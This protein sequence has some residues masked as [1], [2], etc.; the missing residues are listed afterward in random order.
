MTGGRARWLGLGAAM[1]G[2]FFVARALAGHWDAASEALASARPGWLALGAA[3]ALAAM[4]AMAWPWRAAQS[5]VGPPLSRSG[6]LTLYFQ[7]EMGKYVPGAV[8]ALVGRAELARRAGLPRGTAYAGVGLS[9]AALYLACA[10]VAALWAAARLSGALG[11]GPAGGPGAEAELSPGWVAVA[12]VAA[13]AGLVALHPR[14]TGPVLARLGSAARPSWGA[15]AGL[16]GRYLPAWALVGLATAALARAVAPSADL[17][18]VG[19]AAAPAW[20]AGFV[21]V[22]APGGIGVREAVFVAAATSLPDGQ[23]VAVALVARLAFVAADAAGAALASGA[24][25]LSGQRARPDVNL[26][27]T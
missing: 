9:L 16:V 8:W 11:N 13:A 10:A 15:A 7:G 4:V 23:A 18:S 21:A 2:A 5:L 26:P 20:L 6:T 1:A 3:L 17:W 14:L 19:L 27:G 22:G 25:R 24:R 12:A